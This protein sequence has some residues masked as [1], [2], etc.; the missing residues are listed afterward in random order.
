[1]SKFDR[2]AHAMGITS[3]LNG[4]PAEVIGGLTYG[5]TPLEMADAYGT[6][7]N[8]GDHFAPTAISKVVFPNGRVDRMGD[9]P[10]AR[11]FPYAQ[12][13]AATSV[14]KQVISNPAGT[15]YAT[16]SGYGCPAA[17][18]TGTAENLANAWFVGYTPRL[19]TAV[20]VGHP[21]GNVPMPDGFGG[22]LAAPIWTDFM[23]QARGGFCGDWTPPTTP[24]SGTAFTGPHSA[25]KNAP[26]ANPGGRTAPAPVPGP[27]TNRQ[28]FSS[29]PQKPPPAI[30]P[31][32]KP[33]PKQQGPPTASN[34]PPTHGNG[35]GNGG[36]SG[37]G[38]G[39]KSH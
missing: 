16:V 12:A 3:K 34:P 22:T 28:L 7:A 39:H 35:G 23:T 36:G 18:K 11:V 2:M 8:G 30:V 15:A 17:G 4:N 29:P 21:G 38:G 24:W 6:L 26:P 9:P 32:T 27:Y 19:S 20:W 13:Y 37:H 31:G 25:P 33:K 14:L 1:M 10:H 5:V